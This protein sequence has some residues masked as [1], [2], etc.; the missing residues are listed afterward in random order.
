MDDFI[1]CVNEERDRF[2]EAINGQR[3]DTK[4]RCSAESLL[5]IYDQM[6]ARLGSNDYISDFTKGSENIIVP[7]SKGEWY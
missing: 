1:K 3:W 6:A 5:V 4:M 7:G 2:V